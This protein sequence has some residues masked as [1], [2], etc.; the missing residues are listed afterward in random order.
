MEFLIKAFSLDIQWWWRDLWKSARELRIKDFCR[1]LA[2]PVVVAFYLLI[3]M[4]V[5]ILVLAAPVISWG[6][7]ALLGGILPLFIARWYVRIIWGIVFL[8]LVICSPTLF[9]HNFGLEGIWFEPSDIVLAVVNVV[10]FVIGI[11]LGIQGR[12][13]LPESYL[14][15][16]R[17]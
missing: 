16:N 12:K 14:P 8:A 5:V 9:F 6:G 7:S 15:E 4:F 2:A 1:H 17:V 11:L 3:G 13:G 10:F